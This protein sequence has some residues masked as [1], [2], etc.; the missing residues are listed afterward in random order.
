M[1][2]GRALELERALGAA[3]AALS[4]RLRATCAVPRPC[5]Q[6]AAGTSRRGACSSAGRQRGNASRRQLGVLLEG[7]SPGRPMPVGF[8]VI[9]QR[10]T[11]CHSISAGEHTVISCSPVLTR[12]GGSME[13]ALDTRC[14]ISLE[15]RDSVAYTMPC[16]HQLCF[17]CVQS[18]TSSSPQC[19]QC[20]QGV[21]S[22]IHTA[23]ADSDCEELVLRS[24]ALASIAA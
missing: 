9:F 13:V 4:R 22:I 11:C 18:R 12:T 2:T 7:P 19:L 16:C 21:Q 24:A 20:K 1:W 6:Q 8:P 17:Y 15:N 14:P 23:R 5:W 3:S 10:D